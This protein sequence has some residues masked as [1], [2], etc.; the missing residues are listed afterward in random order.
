M[1]RRRILAVAIVALLLASAVAAV[2]WWVFATQVETQPVIIAEIVVN[3]RRVGGGEW[4]LPLEIFETGGEPLDRV[5]VTV[6]LRWSL[7]YLGREPYWDKVPVKFFA[8]CFWQ[9]DGYYSWWYPGG[10]HGDVVQDSRMTYL[11]YGVEQGLI[12]DLLSAMGWN[13]KDRLG[14][15]VA[16][17]YTASRTAESIEWFRGFVLRVRGSMTSTLMNAY[18][19]ALEK[20]MGGEGTVFKEDPETQLA[21]GGSWNSLIEGLATWL[22]QEFGYRLAPRELRHGDEYTLYSLDRRGYELQSD[23]GWIVFDYDPWSQGAY[24]LW[25]DREGDVIKLSLWVFVW[26]Q[27]QDLNGKWSDVRYAA[28]RIGTLTVKVVGGEWVRVS[29]E[30]AATGLFQGSW[31]VGG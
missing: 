11:P 18:Q 9:V 21:F 6:K 16:V 26:Y 20:A 30:T 10:F 14:H 24:H 13:W 8:V 5:Q 15:Y 1:S 31:P 28:R 12:D 29:V 25:T 23:L 7:K 22:E 2:A 4:R 27:W 19:A 17:A 3:G